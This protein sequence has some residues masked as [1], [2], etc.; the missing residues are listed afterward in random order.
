MRGCFD[1][2]ESGVA[3]GWAYDARAPEAAVNVDIF[4]DGRLAATVPAS[5]PRP[6]LQSAGIGTGRY[7]FSFSIP[8]EANDGGEHRIDI[9][10]SGL[11]TSL[12]QSPRTHVLIVSQHKGRLDEANENGRIWGWAFDVQ[13]PNA[14]VFVQLF[15]DGCFI[16]SKAADQP[17][18][19]VKPLSGGD[20]RHGFEFTVPG[21]FLD[22]EE[23]L[24]EM[25]F[26]GG[27]AV[28]NTPL[29]VKF[30][31]SAE[32]RRR[33]TERG[34][35]VRPHGNGISVIIPTHNRADLLETTLR[36][37][38][39]C[40]RSLPVEIVVIDDGSRDDTPQRL[41]ALEKEF[42]LT[43][44]TVSQGGPA[45]ARNVGASIANNDLI[46]FMG[47]D[48]RPVSADFFHYHL[49]SHDAHPRPNVAVLGK[50]VWP[51]EP[52]DEVNFIMSHIQ[53]AGQEQFGF[54]ALTPYTWLDW[55]FFYTSNVSMKKRA[56]ADWS[57]EG[58]SSAFPLAAF[59]DGEFAYRLSQRLPQ[60]FRVLYVPA[61]SVAHHHPYTMRQ[62]MNR[63]V[64]SGMMATVFLRMHPE[65][66]DELALGD[67]LA[68]LHEPVRPGAAVEEYAAVI[69][70]I[71]AWAAILEKDH[72]LGSQNWH[73]DVT[74][75]VFEL[76]FLQGFVLGYDDPAANQPAAYK[77][78]LER[79][80]RRMS[81]SISIEA[82]G[83][84]PQYPIA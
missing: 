37:C 62:F 29:P 76:S 12:E 36:Q 15:V 43:W 79:F 14:R 63:Q 5:Q 51:D 13:R 9:R 21:K 83:R 57:T 31:G 11:S 19:D 17:R 56:V 23:H 67:I 58:F 8:P 34:S 54:A 27:G 46:L 41:A 32:V 1:R 40:A 71:K 3:Y 66:R 61:A 81:Q 28:P 52:G 2:L 44:Q 49:M 47:D 82:F 77:L 6:D 45:R 33:L 24:I 74:S 35:A 22:N 72:N 16:A 26:A 48:T 25:Y 20:G 65:V 7:G 4:I 64:S 50:I 10:H 68:R 42:P 30:I 18:L 55:R 73:R 69:E 80:Q 70:G 39:E 78:I 75:A 53:G 60:G 38:F 59:E 84:L